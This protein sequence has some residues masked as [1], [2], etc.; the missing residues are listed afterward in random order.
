MAQ[1]PDPMLDRRLSEE[2]PGEALENLEVMCQNSRMRIELE[3]FLHDGKTDAEVAV[4]TVS[5]LR[6]LVCVSS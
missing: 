6:R 4:V 1:R 3:R 5:D 2:I